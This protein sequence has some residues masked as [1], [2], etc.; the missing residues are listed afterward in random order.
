MS[1]FVKLAELLQKQLTEQGTHLYLLRHGQSL[2]NH[3]GS[4]VGWTDSKL[5]VK[6]REQANKLFRS[7]HKHVDNFTHI[8]TSDLSRTRD[9]LNLALGFPLRPI[10]INASLREL[11]FGDDEGV[12]FD[13]LPAA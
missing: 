9:T 6:G 5:S 4:I 13:S 1:N 8:H 12:H 10:I 7:F 3:A 11:N 2:A